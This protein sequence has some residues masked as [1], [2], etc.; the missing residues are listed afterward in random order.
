[1]KGQKGFVL[2]HKTPFQGLSLS[3]LWHKVARW[4][5]LGHERR[6][7]ASLSD[8]ALKDLGLTRVDVEHERVR[9]FWDDPMHK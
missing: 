4:Y 2:V 5:T 7:L 1:M 3:V 9:P 8:E 6:M